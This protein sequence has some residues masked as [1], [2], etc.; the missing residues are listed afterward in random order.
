MDICRF[1]QTSKTDVCVPS[2]LQGCGVKLVTVCEGFCVPCALIKYI[3]DSIAGDVAVERFGASKPRL[4]EQIGKCLGSIHS[5][6]IME[7]SN[8]ISYKEWGAVDVNRHAN[9]HFVESI[10]SK[11]VDHFTKLYLEEL[12]ESFTGLDEYPAGII[13]GDPFLDNVMVRKEHPFDITALVDFEDSCV[14]PVMF[15]IGSAIAGSCFADS[16][17]GDDKYILEWDSVRH[18]YKGYISMRALSAREEYS[19]VKFI[20]IALT[21]N[22]AFRFMTYHGTIHADAYLDLFEKLLYL[23]KEEKSIAE[24]IKN[25]LRFQCEIRR[26][27]VI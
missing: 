1:I 4:M 5:L 23:R 27:N 25:I 13:H 3:P 22:C 2:P 10:K 6:N 8:L 20:R 16:T 24:C 17:Q 21:C 7:S 18:F 9:H 11:N 12:E 14:G 26:T 15:D 19:I